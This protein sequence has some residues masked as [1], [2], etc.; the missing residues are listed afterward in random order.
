MPNAV[1]VAMFLLWQQ[2][3]IT[4]TDG[5]LEAVTD[6]MRCT[7][8]LRAL[9]P[10]PCHLRYNRQTAL[11][12]D[13]ISAETHLM[14]LGLAPVQHALCG[15]HRWGVRAAAAAKKQQGLYLNVYP[16]R[17]AYRWSRACSIELPT[18]NLFALPS[19]RRANLLRKRVGLGG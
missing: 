17:S 10:R 2:Q 16:L 3:G 8:E 11:A 18:I 5:T 4:G 14:G 1:A 12:T 13:K 19:R 15:D 6:W 7:Q 9:V